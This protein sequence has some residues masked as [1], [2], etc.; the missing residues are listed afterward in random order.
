MKK[1]TATDSLTLSISERIQL[2]K[3]RVS[4]LTID[5]C[6][7]SLYYLFSSCPHEI[8]T[9]LPIFFK[10]ESFSDTESSFEN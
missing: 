7:H 8:M 6:S 10:H 9:M 5:I 2:G 1:I 4:D 3:I